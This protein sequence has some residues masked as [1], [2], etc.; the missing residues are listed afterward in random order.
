MDA[1]A[2]SLKAQKVLIIFT[3]I[4]QGLLNSFL[5]VNLQQK[6]GHIAIMVVEKSQLLIILKQLAKFDVPCYGKKLSYSNFPETTWVIS[7]SSK[8]QFSPRFV[9]FLG[10]EL[11]AHQSWS[12]CRCRKP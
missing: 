7:K 8:Y 3:V 9:G 11:S 5:E 6:K 2:Q 1:S 4:S 10:L 12:D